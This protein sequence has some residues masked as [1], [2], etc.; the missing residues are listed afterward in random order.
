M[1]SVQ[2]HAGPPPSV[3]TLRLL[4]L[5]TERERE[6]LREFSHG[7]LCKQVADRLGISEATVKTHKENIV[8]KLGV[9]NL[10]EA[11]TKCTGFTC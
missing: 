3:E 9:K 7:L 8:A 11:V 5:L 10:A 2:L 6:V 4:A 1:L